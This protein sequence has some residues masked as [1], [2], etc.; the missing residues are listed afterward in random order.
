VVEVLVRVEFGAVP[1]QEEQANLPPVSCRPPLHG[2]GLMDG[3]PVDDHEHLPPGI[4]TDNGV[5]R[6]Q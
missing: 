2:C 1:G 6:W 4:G 5:E 3:M